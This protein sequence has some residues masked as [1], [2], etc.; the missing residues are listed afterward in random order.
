MPPSIEEAAGTEPKQKDAGL[1]KNISI[2][3]VGK[4]NVFLY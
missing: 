3:F 1:V 2:S 4:P